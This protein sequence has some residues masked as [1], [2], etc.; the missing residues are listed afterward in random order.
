MD[1]DLACTDMMA[2]AY[3]I[4]APQCGDGGVGRVRLSAK[5]ASDEAVAAI[6]YASTHR[7]AWFWDGVGGADKRAEPRADPCIR[8]NF[9]SHARVRERR[10][11]SIRIIA[12]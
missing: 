2:R 1:I 12:S 3:A 11:V 8:V 9:L 5:E 6:A 4:I 7:T 10:R